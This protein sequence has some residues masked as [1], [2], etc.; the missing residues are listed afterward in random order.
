MCVQ[1]N[2]EASMRRRLAQRELGSHQ[3]SRAVMVRQAKEA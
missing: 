1:A 2:G 3:G